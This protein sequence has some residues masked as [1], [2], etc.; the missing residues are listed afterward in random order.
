VRRNVGL[1]ARSIERPLRFGLRQHYRTPPWSDLVEVYWARGV[2]AYV[3]PVAADTVN[4]ALL[5]SDAGRLR[6]LSPFTE[7]EARLRGAPVS[8]R[9]LG[10]GPFRQGA[11]ARHRGRIALVGD[12]AGYL[13][14]IT[15]EGIALALESAEA[16][17]G[18]IVR[19]APLNEYEAAYA[20]LSRSY[21]VTTELALLLAR[22]PPLCKAA[23]SALARSPAAFSRILGWVGGG[24]QGTETR[25]GVPSAELEPSSR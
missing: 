17:V 15:G 9:S 8:S 11:I 10:A 3:T 22:H 5:A 21:S 24:R 14:A 16:L 1:Q 4:V 25:F 13:D 6:N 20:K 12:A 19:G 18:V 7:L 2:E 23:V